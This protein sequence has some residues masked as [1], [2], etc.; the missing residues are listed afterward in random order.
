MCTRKSC[1]KS[2][3]NSNANHDSSHFRSGLDKHRHK[4]A[5]DSDYEAEQEEEGASQI[6]SDSEPLSINE[7]TG[8]TEVLGQSVA[9][10]TE[11]SEQAEEGS[12]GKSLRDTVNSDVPSLDSMQE[13]TQESITI[14]SYRTYVRT[15]M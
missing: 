8:Q 6:S 13:Q 9:G 12:I 14:V 5:G 15:Y 11:A 1:L 2:S 4:V 10:S 7:E 3:Q